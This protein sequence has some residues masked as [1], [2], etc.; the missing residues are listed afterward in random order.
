MSVAIGMLSL[1]LVMSIMRGFRTELTQRLI[2]FDSHITISH[3]PDAPELQREN[4]LSILKNADVRGVMP[5][6]QGEVVAESAVAGTSAAQG[7]RLRGI[8]LSNLS[9]LGG[10]KLYFPEDDSNFDD[11]GGDA[12]AKKEMPS[13]IVGYEIASQLTVHPDFGDNLELMA[14]L[15]DLLP[16]GELG[17]ISRR[18]RVAGVFK[19]GIYNYDGKYI[20]TGIEDAKKLLGLQVKNGWQIN[21]N[22]LKDVPAAVSVLRTALPA[23]WEVLGW[24]EQNKKLF[25]A[26]KLERIAMTGVLLMVVIIASFAIVG[27]VFLVTSSK[28]KDIAMLESL[29]FEKRGIGLVF[30]LH[31]AFIGGIGSAIGFVLG[32]ILCLVLEKFPISLPASYYLEWLPVDTN[33]AASVIFVL[34]GIVIAI[35]SSMYPVKQAISQNPVEVLRY[36]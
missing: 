9:E 3:L 35:V 23:G 5:F 10:V 34:V 8:E 13:V 26:L 6:V 7:A 4:I 2:G 17:P 18:F 14:P 29:G 28:R 11:D 24:N 12:R 19:T 22:D 21:L 16:N 1:I 30:L 27:I 20:F 36:E 15:A 32:T 31:A 33:P 25:A